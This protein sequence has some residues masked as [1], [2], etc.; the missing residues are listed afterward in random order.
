METKFNELLDAVKKCRKYC[1]FIQEQTT[2]KHVEEL[3]LE[4]QEVIEALEKDDNENLQEELGDVFWDLLMTIIIAEQENKINSK[5]VIEDVIQ[6]FR[7][8][9]PSIFEE[10]TLPK[11]EV[12]R[13]WHEAKAKEKR[14]K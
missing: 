11:E 10:K 1:P 7:R 3:R 5:Q 14:R 9:K 8:R 13:V 4:V 6:K 12:H 2:E